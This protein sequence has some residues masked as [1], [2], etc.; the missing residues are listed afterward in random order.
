MFSKSRL[1]KL[2]ALLVV[3]AIVLEVINLARP[4]PAVHAN[5]LQL[6]VPAS[7][8]AALPWPDYGQ[9]AYGAV[10]FGVLATNGAQASAPIASIAK[11]ITALSVLRQK[12]LAVGQQGPTITLGPNDVALYQQYLAEDGSVVPV[13]NGEQISEYQALQAMLLPSANNMADSLANWAF[14]SQA[15]YLSYANSYVGSLGLTQTHVADGSGFSPDSV[16][17]AH[18]LVILGETVLANP[19]LA[20]IVSQTTATIPVAGTVHNVN[21]LLGSSG[22]NGIKTGNT[23]QAGG[24]FLFSA[25]RLIDGQTIEVVGAILGAPGGASSPSQALDAARPVIESADANFE[26]ADVKAGQV[27]GNYVSPWGAST[28]AVAAKNISLLI[29]KGQSPSI[30]PTLTNLKTSAPAG[31]NVGSVQL[32]ASGKS[33]SSSVVIQ[34][35]IKK[36][37]ITWRLTHF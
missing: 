24:C 37:P 3:V 2:V 4:L 20:D 23:D 22:I 1:F 28:K 10:G 14:G 12:P 35:V 21:W 15:A 31:T 9:A 33:L 11:T 17:S 16:S 26:L 34:T 29:W 13:T 36:P 30:K 19:V 8:A 27:I 5:P 25:T 6:N 7:S 18:D 32:S